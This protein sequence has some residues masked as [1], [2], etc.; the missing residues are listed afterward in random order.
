MKRAYLALLTC[1]CVSFFASPAYAAD[2]GPPTVLPE[3]PPPTTS[4]TT[5]ATSPTAAAA[6]PELPADPG[7][8]S[9]WGAGPSRWFLSLLVDVGVVYL[10]PRVAVGWGRPYTEW[11]GLEANPIISGD[12][13]GASGG[14]RIKGESLGLDL[15]LGGRYMASLGRTFL[16]RQKDYLRQDIELRVGNSAG[17]TAF[18][19]ELSGGWSIGGGVDIFAEAAVTYVTGVPDGFDVFE[20]VIKAVVEPPWVVRGRA[21]W[22]F[23]LGFQG[24]LKAGPVV[25]VVAIPGRQAY[26]LRGG[27][28]GS[29]KLYDNLEVRLTIAPAFG[30]PDALG[31]RGGDAFVLGIRWR[32]AT[33]WSPQQA[34]APPPRKP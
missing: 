24:A 34:P 20:E 10:R 25:E 26:I 32:W 7:V 15:R 29:L 11:V 31:T 9:S 27:I 8:N 14:L 3:P 4:T 33:G 23:E 5:P 1:A 22:T 16:V 19:G 17:Y 13:L 21:G 6:V 30:S 18:E 2:P 12:T 28:V